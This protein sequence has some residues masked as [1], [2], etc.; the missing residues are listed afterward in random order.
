MP[1]AA[2][3]HDAAVRLN[4]AP[5]PVLHYWI[6]AVLLTA[7]S[8]AARAQ[9]QEV[10]D[11]PYVPTPPAVVAAMLKLAEAGKDDVVYDLGS[12]DGR[13]VIA[14]ARNFNVRRG[15]GIDLDPELVT[16]AASSARRAGVGDR[17]TFVQDNIFR[18]DFSAA[19]IV[20][21]YLTPDVNLR[22]R[23]RFMQELRPGTRIVSHSANMGD[24][25]PDGAE[26][27]ERRRIYL[28]I[29]PAK[30][31]GVWRT[32]DAGIALDLTQHHQQVSGTL[33]V[34][35]SRAP[36]STAVLRGETITFKA[37]AYDFE[38]KVS[39]DVI[40]GILRGAGGERTVTLK[41][42]P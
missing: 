40:T 12:G 33:K 15:V 10:L 39:G 13:I 21:L 32:G 28:W 19:T 8:A 1:P 6:I 31:Q 20:T 7:L 4:S 42:A 25:V 24:W 41:R 34:E 26:L 16:R 35:T 23:P 5:M 9:T 37:G 22:L 27:A 18:A 30:V 17:V 29:V 2:V 36:I 14:A 11:V 38:G 3:W